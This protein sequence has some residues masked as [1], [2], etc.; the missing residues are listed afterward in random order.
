L[1]IDEEKLLVFMQ[2]L[3]L[4]PAAVIVPMMQIAW[5]LFSIINGALLW[6]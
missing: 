3:R 2:A 4:F 5:T 1:G 6:R